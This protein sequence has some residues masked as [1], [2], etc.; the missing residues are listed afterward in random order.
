MVAGI[1]N[2]VGGG[3]LFVML[4]SNSSICPVPFPSRL[5]TKRMSTATAVV[6]NTLHD[7]IVAAIG[8]VSRRIALAVLGTKYLAAI[9]P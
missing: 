3:I 5:I 4:P 8:R 2:S 9:P 7:A 1:C 6:N